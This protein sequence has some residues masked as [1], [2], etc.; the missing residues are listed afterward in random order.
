MQLRSL[1]LKANWSS[2]TNLKPKS[3]ARSGTLLQVVGALSNREILQRPRS[4]SCTICFPLGWQHII[5]TTHEEES[6]F[7]AP[8]LA[9][10]LFSVTACRRTTAP[11]ISRHGN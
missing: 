9:A 6:P 1:S 7:H 3:N 11:K 8:S 4:D 5:A 10:L 2:P